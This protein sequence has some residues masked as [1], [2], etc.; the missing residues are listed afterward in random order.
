MLGAHP[1]SDISTKLL[2]EG[3]RIRIER[4]DGSVD[5]NELREF[6]STITFQKDEIKKFSTKDIINKFDGSAAEIGRD[7]A[8]HFSDEINR[9]TDETG[10]VINGEGQPF[11]ADLFLKMLEKIFI[12]FDQNGHQVM[13]TITAGPK[14]AETIKNELEKAQHNPDYCRRFEEIISKKR[15]EWR[16]RESSRKLVG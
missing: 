1:F 13:P 4:A 8:K 16:D 6:S 2:Y 5:D 11:S 15:E 9:M 14:L 3:N 7:M 10:N 12:N